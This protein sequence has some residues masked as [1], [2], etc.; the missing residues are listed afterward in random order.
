MWNFR[1]PHDIEIRIQGQ[2]ITLC[3]AVL[4]VVNNFCRSLSNRLNTR[5][6]T[7]QHIKSADAVVRVMNAFVHH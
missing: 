7:V 2:F 4:Q 5:V 6:V 3:Y 1:S